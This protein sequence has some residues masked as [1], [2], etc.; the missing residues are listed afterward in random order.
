MMFVDGIELAEY[1]IDYAT[2][3]GATY[4]EARFLDTIK[5]GVGLV[6]GNVLS[7]G[8][9][10]TSGIGLRL[11][12]E[13]GI[14][15]ASF[16]T[17]KKDNAEK[18]V[19]FALKLAK[20]S[21]RKNNPVVFSEEEIVQDKWSVEVKQRP[22]NIS[23]EDKITK[24][25]ELDKLLS[26]KDRFKAEIKGRN[27]F[28]AT[29]EYHKYFVNN[30]GTKI[31]NEYYSLI[32]I[33][34]FVTAVSE[35][36]SEQ[37]FFSLGATM[38]WEWFKESNPYEEIVGLVS[39]IAKAATNAK[40]FHKDVTDMVVGAQVAGIIAH[41][42]AGHPSEADRI[43]GRE[44]AEAGES[45]VQELELGK[46][47]VGSDAVTVIDDPTIPKSGGYYKYDD[48]G[49]KARPRYLIKNGIF[50]E[51]LHNRETAAL[52]GTKST[53]AARA[54]SYDREP[55]VRMANTFIAPGEYSFEELL[56]DIKDGIFMK[57]F[58][59]WNI[60]DRRFQS[61][62]VGSIAYR[63]VNGEITDEMI[64]RPVIELTTIGLFTSIDAV[65][66]G[67]KAEL[68][69][70]GKGNPMQGIPVYTA[71]PEGVRMRNIRLSR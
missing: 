41:E 70:C 29:T 27:I 32:E 12:Y 1:V 53:A 16:E 7:A 49:V 6:N 40:T 42:N 50:T 8:Q 2:A 19:N 48:E 47:R 51:L 23:L 60:D 59:E 24:I 4:A 45:Y 30:E 15:F 20:A 18:A 62:Y 69:M 71:G 66:K 39:E 56:D 67:F 58:S 17:L 33:T 44:G 13:G 57:T 10:K 21:G 25:K 28:F 68:A 34:N 43:W 63:I 46:S 5:S 14:A 61:K 11:I 38:G 35:N 3:K 54:T 55:I 64:K 22:I 37:A 26:D 52:W 36:G 65:A 9:N 31:D